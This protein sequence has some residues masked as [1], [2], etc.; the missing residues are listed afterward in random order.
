MT[1]IPWLG[2]AIVL[3]LAY[4]SYRLSVRQWKGNKRNGRN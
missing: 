2:I 1:G 4:I 3:L